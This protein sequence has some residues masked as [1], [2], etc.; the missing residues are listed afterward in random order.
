MNYDLLGIPKFNKMKTIKYF[1]AA[2]TQNRLGLG[3][4]R[5]IVGYL[6]PSAFIALI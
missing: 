4:A 1:V 5:L 6:F 3:N 2:A